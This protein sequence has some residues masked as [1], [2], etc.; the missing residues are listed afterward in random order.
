VPAINSS[1]N[2]DLH[3]YGKDQSAARATKGATCGMPLGDALVQLSPA[4]DPAGE[5]FL[6]T[7]K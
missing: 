6:V 3:R 7:L 4:S 5:A 1:R 2:P